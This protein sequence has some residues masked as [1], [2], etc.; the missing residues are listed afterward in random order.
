MGVAILL[1]SVINQSQT[2][3]SYD[4]RTRPLA[5]SPMGELW[6]QN[7]PMGELWRQNSP[8]PVIGQ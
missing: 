1:T 5:N 6:R 4:V 7:S 3:A 8:M 2:W